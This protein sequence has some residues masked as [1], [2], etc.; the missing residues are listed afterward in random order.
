MA[1]RARHRRAVGRTTR[2]RSG[3][4]ALPRLSA[5]ARRE[6]Y[7]DK[8]V[9]LLHPQVPGTVVSSEREI[10][11]NQRQLGVIAAIGGIAWILAVVSFNVLPATPEGYVDMSL[12]IPGLAMG[13]VMI[14]IALSELGTRHGS[15]TS[16]RTGHIAAVISVVLAGSL[17]MPWPLMVIGFLGFPVLAVVAVLR[18][19]MNR[20]IPGWFVAVVF[21]VA[22]LTWIAGILGDA[23]AGPWALVL[24][25]PAA[26]VLAW[27][28]FSH[29]RTDGAEVS[30]A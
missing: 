1:G 4:N 24:V 30:P 14:G 28:A 26:F 17:F 23:T 5:A 8:L 15:A 29:R 10:P 20:A 12:A 2:A 7:G 13:I 21:V 25:G 18:G 6:R 3:L 27:S 9:A 16:A 11:M 22:A 19:A